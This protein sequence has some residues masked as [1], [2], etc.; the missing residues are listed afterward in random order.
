[1]SV[2]TRF[3]EVYHFLKS[4]KMVKN[5]KEFAEKI[6]ISPSMFTEIVN[7]RSGVGL[8]A[9]QNTVLNYNINANWLLTGREHISAETEP[10]QPDT[11][12]TQ[13][14]DKIEEQARQIG[15]LEAQDNLNK[16][17]DILIKSQAGQIERL[18]AEILSL[19]NDAAPMVAGDA[20]SAVSASQPPCHKQ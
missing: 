11:S 16:Q 1:M 6:G 20:V 17:K 3:L 7:G 2:S 15:R 4:N 12:V 5:Q 8:S 9:I 19:K 13:L 14:L 10:P 18:E